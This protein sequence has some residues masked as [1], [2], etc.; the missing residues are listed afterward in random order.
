MNNNLLH[1]TMTP[2]NRTTPTP[3]HS[4]LHSTLNHY[5]RRSNKRPVLK[6]AMAIHH[7]KSAAARAAV[8]QTKQEINQP[9][10]ALPQSHP[11]CQPATL[12]VTTPHVIPILSTPSEVLNSP[13]RV[14]NA[15]NKPRISV[16][17]QEIRLTL[18]SSL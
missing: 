18:P 16:K 11:R 8:T 3:Y 5:P 6:L 15:T 9:N 13:N 4:I 2:G 14:L 10:T 7:H 17:I 1:L 12:H